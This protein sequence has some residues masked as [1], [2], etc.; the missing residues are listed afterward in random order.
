MN[1]PPPPD[2][3]TIELANTERTNAIASFGFTERQAKFLVNVLLHSGVFVERQY[4]GFAGIVHGQ[5]STDFVKTLVERRFATPIATGKLHRGRMFHVHY[6]P[7]WAAIGE[8]DNRFR[9]AAAPGRMIE[10]VML[11]DAVLDATTCAWLGPAID[12]RRHFMRHLESRLE[13]REYPHLTFGDGPERTV[14]YF[15]DKFPIAVLPELDSHAFVY[16]VTHPSP[17]DFRLFLLRHVALFRALFRWTIRLLFPRS[18]W[19]ARLV[20]Q[21]AAREHLATRL[22]PANVQVLEWL[23]PERKRLAEPGASP[24]D[25]RYLTASKNFSAPKFRALYRQWLEDPVDTLWM[26]GSNTIADALE[27]GHGRVEC[28]E[29]SRQYLHL[30]PLV[31]VA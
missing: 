31:D 11:L 7:L 1:L 29:L 28:V 26:A 13:A 9:K 4:C 18:L 19:K 20:Y 14:R 17:M 22:E 21:H 25:E 12:K 2:R 23:F 5:K 10:R 3:W 30:S 27:R 24:A 15:P 6:K 16:L 8:P